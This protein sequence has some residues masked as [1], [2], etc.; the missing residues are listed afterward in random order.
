MRKLFAALVKYIIMF[1]VIVGLVWF[2]GFK[3][4]EYTLPFETFMAPKVDKIAFMTGLKEDTTGYGAIRDSILT[5]YDEL[6]MEIQA[7]RAAIVARNLQL[8][9]LIQQNTSFQDS[10]IDE[11]DKLIA[12]QIELTAKEDENL[13]K[14]AKIYEAMKPNEAAGI[15][16]QL[17]DQAAV[18]ILYKMSEQA[19]G[20]LIAALGDPIRAADISNRYRRLQTEI[21]K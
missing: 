14:L 6:E 9:T 20:K 21:K 5:P 3:F 16:L 13:T 12:K 8:D 19:A 17:S 2:V 1:A 4:R 7:S 10:L 11:K 15:I 18:E